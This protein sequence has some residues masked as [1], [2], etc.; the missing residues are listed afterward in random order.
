MPACTRV[1]KD[2]NCFPS[3]SSRRNLASRA[4]P[5]RGSQSSLA[6]STITEPLPALDQDVHDPWPPGRPPVPA[7]N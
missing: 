4:T 7:F 2:S 1:S 3:P 5:H 6:S